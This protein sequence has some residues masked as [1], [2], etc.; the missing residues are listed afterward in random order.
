M[1][2]PFAAAALCASL[3]VLFARDVLAACGDGNLETRAEEECDD[4]NTVAG[5]G[6]GIGCEMECVEVGAPATEHTCLH[7]SNGPFAQRGSTP[8]PG[9]PTTDVDLTHTYYSV[10]LSG[11]PGANRSV[12]AYRPSV[13]GDVAIYMKLPYPLRVLDAAGEE[14]PVRIEHA[15]T[16][17]AQADAITWVRV[18]PEL[19]GDAEYTLDMGPS[20]EAVFSMALENLGFQQAMYRDAD[21][22]GF[23]LKGG[24]PTALSWCA[25][26]NGYATSNLDCDD[27][28]ATTY[29][30]ASESCD[31]QN[32]DCDGL[33]DSMEDGIC[34]GAA[35]GSTC[36]ELDGAWFCGC[37]DDEECATGNCVEGLCTQGA[38]SGSS[39]SGSVGASGDTGGQAPGQAAEDRESGCSCSQITSGSETAGFLS[40]LAALLAA[41]R[42]RRGDATW[43]RNQRIER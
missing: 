2:R 31:G 42:R 9:P 19:E 25:P 1:S 36:R 11:T 3:A 12:I 15:V 17:C 13:T 35:T 26:P 34:D 32:S 6:C 41:A 8:Y 33:D 22:D 4:G 20:P 14:V 23:G 27:E 40:S 28:S 37:F 18:Y 39:A 7:G 16:T 29:P 5:D 21:H 38:A 30:A 24:P 43:N 10:T